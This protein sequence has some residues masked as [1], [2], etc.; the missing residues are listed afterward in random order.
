MLLHPSPFLQNG[1]GSLCILLWRFEPCALIQLRQSSRSQ[2]P[3]AVCPFSVC[4]EA[5]RCQGRLG[6][7]LSVLKTAAGE[8]R[9]PE[10]GWGRTGTSRRAPRAGRA[11]RVGNTG[12]GGALAAQDGGCPGPPSRAG[13]A[14]ARARPR[15]R[16]WAGG[17][18]RDRVTA[19]RRRRPWPTWRSCSA[20]T[21][22]RRPS[23]KVRGAGPA[24][25][26]RCRSPP[27]AGQAVGSRLGLGRSRQGGERGGG[28]GT[29]PL[30]RE[31]EGFAPGL[32]GAGAPCAARRGGERLQGG[33]LGLRE[34]R[35]SET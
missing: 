23:R 14:R 4:P 32:R 11:P 15:A 13:R 27:R 30:R 28:V 5:E 7:D 20:A 8:N 16:G 9:G 24:R 19:R 29:A 25:P 22:T 33:E 12:L 3:V 6:C 18:L 17:A 26:C 31:P 10:Q 1:P 34:R 35:R 2:Q 21:P